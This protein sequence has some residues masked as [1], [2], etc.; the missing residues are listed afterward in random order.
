MDVYTKL[1]L[2]AFIGIIM[3]PIGVL[4]GY[5]IGYYTGM[6][7]YEKLKKKNKKLLKKNSLTTEDKENDNN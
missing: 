3:F 4:T 2:I 1:Y 5:K 7:K 6:I